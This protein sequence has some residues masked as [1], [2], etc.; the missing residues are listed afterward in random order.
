MDKSDSPIQLKFNMVIPEDKEN[1]NIIPEILEHKENKDKNIVPEILEHEGSKDKNIIPEILEHKDQKENKDQKEQK[2][3]KEQKEQKENKENKEHKEHKEQK[4]NKDQKE[5]KENKEHKDQ[6]EIKEQKEQKENKENKEHKE[7]KEQKEN[8]DQKDQ[9]ENKENKEHKE[10]KEQKE[11]KDQKEIKDN[12][13]KSTKKKSNKLQLPINKLQPKLLL[14][15][16]KFKISLDVKP[17]SVNTTYRQFRGRTILSKEARIWKIAVNNL[18]LNK[19]KEAPLLNTMD[20]IIN[21]YFKDRRC[22]DIDNF[23]KVTLDALNKIVYIDDSQIFKLEL[24]KYIGC[25]NYRIDIIIIARTPNEKEIEGA[26]N[27]Y[28]FLDI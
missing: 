1:K 16:Q 27:K 8:K 7:H 4:E 6:K 23:N 11:N 20:I 28:K 13:H 12:I 25:N 14:D 9:K 21:F 19:W 18:I 26:K 17:L 22:V 3:N 15:R 5:Q 24:N 10:H 2:E